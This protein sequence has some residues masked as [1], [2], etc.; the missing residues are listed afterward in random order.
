M[1]RK[2]RNFWIEFTFAILFVLGFSI[3][4]WTFIALIVTF[5]N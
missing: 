4:L 1:K 5:K 3:V 2:K